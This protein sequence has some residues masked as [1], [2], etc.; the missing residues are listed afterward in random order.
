[1]K[2]VT[3]FI[4]L[5][6]K[7]TVKGDCSHEI[8]RCLLLG[9]KAM[10][11]LDSIFKSRGLSLLDR[12]PYSQSCDF[13][14]VMYRW[15]MKNWYFQTIVLEKTLES[16]L[17]SKEIKQ[18]NSKGNQPWIFTG[19]TDAKA[20]TSILWPP[21]AIPLQGRRK[22]GK[23]AQCQHVRILYPRSW[24]W[25][26]RVQLPEGQN[27]WMIKS[28]CSYWELPWLGTDWHCTHSSAQLQSDRYLIP[29]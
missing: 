27:Y 23:T 1:M 15:A 19:R 5:S 14:V 22:R 18:V 17:G 26:Q 3:D 29:G 6:F 13:P 2:T 20:E 9:R 21:D 8:Q 12:S 24:I 25:G 11:N 28:A 16:P 4:S 10:T 7:I